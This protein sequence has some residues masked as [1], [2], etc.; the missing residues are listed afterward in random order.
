MQNLLKT[1]VNS[2]LNP[3]SLTLNR[4]FLFY[5]LQVPHHKRRVRPVLCRNH[6]FALPA[7]CLATWSPL[8]STRERRFRRD[9]PAGLSTA[10]IRMRKARVFLHRSQGREGTVHR[11]GHRLQQ[12]APSIYV[13]VF[14]MFYVLVL[15]FVVGDEARSRGS[16][17]MQ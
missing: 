13:R 11:P 9:G 5:D 8:H 2:T 12:V 16:R 1:I 15:G 3:E 17:Y 7:L 4:K 14:S 10:K 6:R